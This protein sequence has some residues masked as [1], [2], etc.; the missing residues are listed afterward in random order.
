MQ[1][2]MFHLLHLQGFFAVKKLWPLNRSV[3]VKKP[4]HEK[5]IYFMD[6][7]NPSEGGVACDSVSLNE[8]GL[9]SVPFTIKTML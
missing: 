7:V 1:I 6:S 4:W 3:T 9:D 5:G 2:C 8:R